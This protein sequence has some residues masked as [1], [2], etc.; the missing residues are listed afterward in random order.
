[1]KT[2]IDTNSLL[3]LVRYYLPFDRKKV[4]YDFIK[5][6]L[7]SGELIIIDKI[8]EQCQFIANGKILT[9]LSFMS[10]KKFMK[11]CKL[12]INTNDFIAPAPKKFL[13]IFDSSFVNHGT[14]KLRGISDVELDNQKAKHLEDADMKMIIMCLNLIQDN[15]VEEVVLVTE[16]TS[17]DNDNK[18]F[19]KIPLMCKVLGI[20]TVTLPVWIKEHTGIDIDFS[21]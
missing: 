12:P 7:I 17:S 19:K 16:E 5:D 2:V 10:D 15:S 20:N 3:F 9:D 1:M 11:E 14:K 6:S 4:L 21:S 18:L 13:N 8:H